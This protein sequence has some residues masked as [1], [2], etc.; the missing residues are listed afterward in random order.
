MSHCDRDSAATTI[1]RMA[2]RLLT[3]VT[4]PKAAACVKGRFFDRLDANLNQLT[5]FDSSELLPIDLQATAT[6]LFRGQEETV[7]C[8]TCAPRPKA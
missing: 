1:E 5:R 6:A 8:K 4:H 2:S 3:A 7:R